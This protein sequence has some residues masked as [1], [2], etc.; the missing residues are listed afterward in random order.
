MAFSA[1]ETKH[2]SFANKKIQILF[3]D[4]SIK[5]V[6]ISVF[7]NKNKTRPEWIYGRYFSSLNE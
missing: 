7:K 2:G 3:E 1:G 5:S 4:D 6:V